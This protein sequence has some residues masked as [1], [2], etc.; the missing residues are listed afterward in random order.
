M[1]KFTGLCGLAMLMVLGVH[2]QSKVL[3]KSLF[4]NNNEG[5]AV[6]VKGNLYVVNFKEDGTIGKVNT[7]TGEVEMW[8]KL[9]NGSVGNGIKFRNANEM[10]VADF[11]N[12]NILL[13]NNVD[14]KVSVFAHDEGMN[15]PNDLAI[16]DNG[17]LYASDPS[18]KNGTGQVWKCTPNGAL[19]KVLW[20][21]GTTNGIAVSPKGKYLYV[22]ESVQRKVWRFK[23]D[24]NGMPTQKK[25]IHQFDDFGM[26]GMRC[27]VN[28]LLYVCRYDAGKVVVMNK[29]GKIVRE[30]TLVGK[31][32]SNIAFGGKD[33]KTAF[34]TLQDLKH[35]ESFEVSAPGL[36]WTNLQQKK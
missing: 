18:W 29:N 26:D 23:L 21:M 10:Y 25:L 33:G 9:P 17:T 16:A 13:V 11:V 34:V 36:E 20:D 1:R 5:P 24:K 8:V 2:A 30:V 22:N 3:T 15:Q 28:G 7:A 35:I 31:K 27:D 32:P 6:D 12:H 19:K 4:T 14:R